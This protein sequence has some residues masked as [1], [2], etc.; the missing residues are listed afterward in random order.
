M[1][2]IDNRTSTDDTTA[3]FWIWWLGL[4]GQPEMIERILGDQE[5]REMSE[6]EY[7]EWEKLEAEMPEFP[8]PTELLW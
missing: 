7:V 8:E 1:N 4:E 3:D 2:K 6:E 5:Y